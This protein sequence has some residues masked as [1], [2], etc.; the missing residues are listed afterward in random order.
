MKIRS[1]EAIPLG[2]PFSTRGTGS[3]F[4][5]ADWS[6]L[7]MVLV[8]IETEE[9]IVG[10][11]DAF[12]YSCW[13]PVTSA[14]RTMF[15][16]LLMG[17]D[18]TN[19]TQLM[20][21]LQVQLHTYGRYGI[22]LYALSG[23]D[24]A[25]WDI[26]AKR[27]GLPLHK[28]LRQKMDET[29]PSISLDE[30]PSIS[31]QDAT[32]AKTLAVGATSSQQPAETEPPRLQ[33][34]ASLF[35]YDDRALVRKNCQ[36]ALDM[37]YAAFKLHENKAEFI[38]AARETLGEESLLCTDVNCC[39]DLEAAQAAA[40]SFAPANLLWLEEPIFPPEDFISLGKLRQQTNI[41]IALGENAC[42]HYEFKQIIAAGAADYLQPSV[43]KVGGI[44][45]FLRVVELAKEHNIKIAPH[46]A[47]F[48]PGLLATMHLAAGVLHAS[49]PLIERFFI[50]PQA[51]LYG[52]NTTPVDGYFQL[53]T[54]AGLGYEPDPQVIKEYRIKLC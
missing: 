15:K 11:G 40:A 18:T 38:I 34:Y 10:W 46:S 39:W 51:S 26:Y 52:E 41:P 36:D 20:H 19:I 32:R 43:S 53:G 31:A 21:S 35:K 8:R 44:T 24:I 54:A 23:I 12:G 13:A 28:L 22:S 1:L 29:A 45:E 7:V 17:A 25:L 2:I 50:D 4:K 37:G 6:R 16:P 42:T 47:Y 33:A 9:G 14:I 5:G 30:K 49:K 48:G 27:A 3:G